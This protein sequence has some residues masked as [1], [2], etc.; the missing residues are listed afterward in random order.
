MKSQLPKEITDDIVAAYDD[1]LKKVYRILIDGGMNQAEI[2][3]LLSDKK[4]FLDIG[5]RL[6][7][8][9]A[10]KE[11]KRSETMCSFRFKEKLKV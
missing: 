4:M 1:F 2:D 3:R 10:V 5:D 8:I 6:I 7:D 11:K 9:M